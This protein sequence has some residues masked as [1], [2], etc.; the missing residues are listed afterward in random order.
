MDFCLPGNIVE[1]R[2]RP[3]RWSLVLSGVR[4]ATLATHCWPLE[5]EAKPINRRPH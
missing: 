4:R 1:R 5:I 3:A 2:Q